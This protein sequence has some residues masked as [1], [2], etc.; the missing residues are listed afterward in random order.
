MLCWIKVLKPCFIKVKCCTFI[1]PKG[2][3]QPHFPHPDVKL[4]LNKQNMKKT[5]F[6]L[7]I[8]TVNSIIAQI[9]LSNFTYNNIDISSPTNLE[10]FNNRIYFAATTDDYGRELWSS[11][12]TPQNTRLV[13]DISP[14]TY[15][16]YTNFYY[17]TKLNNELYFVANYDNQYTGSGEIWKTDGTEAGSTFVSTFT[18][19][20][21]GLT[22]VGNQIYST[23]K[24]SEYNMQIWKSDGTS[25]GSEIVKDNI[26]I[27]NYPSFQGSIN[28][29]FVFTIQHQ[30]ST[31]SKVWRSDGTNAGTYP[32]T[33]EIDGNGSAMGGTTSLSQY[34]VFND[35]LYFITRFYLYKTDGT[36][37]NSVTTVWNAMS[38][39]VDFGDVI[40]LN[41]NMYFSFYSMN[42]KKL[43][44]YKSNGTSSGTSIIHNLTSNEYFY[45]SYF[46]TTGNNLIF[47]SKNPNNG[48]SIFHYNTTT[49]ITSEVIQIDQAPLAPPYFL[50]NYTALSLDRLNEDKFYVCSPV[51]LAHRRGWIFNETTLSL[52]PANALDN[53]IHGIRQKIVFNNYLLYVKDYQLWK[54]D[55]NTLSS[56]VFNENETIQIFPNPTSEFIS[57]CET[58]EISSIKF[59]DM[60]GKLVLDTPKLINNKVAV[61][62]LKSGVYNLVVL[63]NN[64]LVSKRI[65][66]SH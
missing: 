13:I 14:A 37:A 8:L 45:P 12:G 57:F 43:I 20:I 60:N 22:T 11:D 24:T 32:L 42:L 50:G 53:I 59:Y 29:I 5:L 7:T 9:Q 52:E 55:V 66:I 25:S 44:I 48:T 28:G 63:K 2:I 40:V 36:T 64:E 23:I 17:S 38:S 62:D 31:K 35:N 56:N 3:I 49:N 6:L 19:R 46:N 33:G 18:G 10:E 1:K 58:D 26:L 39:P 34:I 4:N 21:F 41:G 15:N 61:D 54:F 51:S 27:L 65:I 16:G 47:T 30:G